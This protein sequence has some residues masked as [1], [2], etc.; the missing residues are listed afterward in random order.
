[1]SYHL[2]PIR[3]TGARILRNGQF[4]RRSIGITRGRLT[5]GPLPQVDLGGYLVLPGIVD[6][7]ADRVAPAKLRDLEAIKA[8]LSREGVTTAWLAVPSDPAPL[9]DQVLTRLNA[10]RGGIDLRAKLILA[11][12]AY[13]SPDHLR[14][15]E[16]QRLD[17]ACFDSVGRTDTGDSSGPTF[18]RELCRMAECLD[19]LGIPYGSLGDATAETREYY[20]MLGARFVEQPRSRA[21]AATAHAMDDCV[22]ATAASLKPSA[23]VGEANGTARLVAEGL[24]DAIVSNGVPGVMSD[25]A[26]ILANGTAEALATAWSLIS[27]RPA[28]LMGLADRGVLEP[29]KRADLTIIH[30]KTRRVEATIAKGRLCFSSSE[31]AARFGLSREEVPMAAE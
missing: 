20:R 9:I 15:L 24:C 12:D 1:M 19:A 18:P 7:H 28:E 16:S 17:F 11:P 13:F 26:W 21:A 25:A 10:I 4:Q 14:R 22:I 31:V 8:R 29:G 6:L 2:P 5:T 23:S 3:L 27:R 30:E